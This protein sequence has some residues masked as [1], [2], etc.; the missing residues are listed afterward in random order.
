MSESFGAVGAAQSAA[1]SRYAGDLVEETLA[2][3][4]RRLAEAQELA[5]AVRLA[6]ESAADRLL[7]A[8][9]EANERDLAT[10]RKQAEDVLRHARAGILAAVQRYANELLEETRK[11]NETRLPRA[12][13]LA[14]LVRLADGPAADR[15]MAAIEEANQRSYETA[16][17]QAN[18]VVELAEA[19]LGGGDH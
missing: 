11:A 16:Q 19:Q 9:T 5:S 3:N 7:G 6:D 10:A 13:E 17:D 14:D 18:S 2:A 1:V 8:A 15:L 12:R 4:E